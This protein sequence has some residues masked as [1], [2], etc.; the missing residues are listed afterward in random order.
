MEALFQGALKENSGG[1]G[2]F[3]DG[4][5]YAAFVDMIGLSCER[6]SMR[7]LGGCL[8]PNHFHLVVCPPEQ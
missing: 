2:V 6:Y 7:V 5:D 3:H 8:M 1:A 4:Y